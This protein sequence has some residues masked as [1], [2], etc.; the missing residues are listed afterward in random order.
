MNRNV[1]A[2]HGVLPEIDYHSVSAEQQQAVSA[3]AGS[4]S[5]GKIY[6]RDVGQTN[7]ALSPSSPVSRPALGN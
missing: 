3:S 5:A 4:A 1:P 7:A 6:Q 2:L